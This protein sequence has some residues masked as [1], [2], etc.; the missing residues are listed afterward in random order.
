VAVILIGGQLWQGNQQQLHGDRLEGGTAFGRGLLGQAMEVLYVGK[1][2]PTEL[3]KSAPP[4]S[5]PPPCAAL[6][7]SASAFST[8]LRLS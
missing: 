6:V 7:T 2:H 5:F 4:P 1:D 8:R 3:R